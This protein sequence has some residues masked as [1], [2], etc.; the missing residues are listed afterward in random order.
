MRTDLR[1][2]L[3]L[4]VGAQ[5]ASALEALLEHYGESGPDALASCRFRALNGW[6]AGSDEPIQL[7]VFTPHELHAYGFCRALNG[8]PTFFVTGISASMKQQ[9]Q[10][11]VRAAGY[12]ALRI[13]ALLN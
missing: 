10:E 3:T 4:V 5:E 12:E 9:S 11:V 7:E 13:H 1:R 8:K 2:E 6:H